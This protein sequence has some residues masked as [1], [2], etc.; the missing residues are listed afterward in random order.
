VSGTPIF[1]SLLEE[2]P[3]IREASTIFPRMDFA[4]TW[5]TITGPENIAEW[6]RAHLNI[7]PTPWQERV[8]AHY[9][10]RFKS[11]VLGSWHDPANLGSVS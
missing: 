10:P 11:R 4:K 1:D 2:R 7:E 9:D 3:G 8:M 5:R 6:V